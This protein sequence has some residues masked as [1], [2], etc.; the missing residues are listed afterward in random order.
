MSS[1]WSSLSALMLESTSC[2]SWPDFLLSLSPALSAL[3]SG[4]GLW[5]GS[6]ARSTSKAALQTS[7]AALTYSAARAPTASVV[8]P[9]EVLAALQK[10]SSTTQGPGFTSTSHGEGLEEAAPPH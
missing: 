9:P 6:R 5:V 2:T 3:L 1:A 10:H 7:Q 8:V 4:I